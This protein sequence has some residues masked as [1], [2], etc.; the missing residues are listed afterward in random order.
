LR[1]GLGHCAILAWT[2]VAIESSRSSV[3]LTRDRD[4]DSKF[5]TE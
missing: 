1:L 3:E 4:M 2:E 5:S